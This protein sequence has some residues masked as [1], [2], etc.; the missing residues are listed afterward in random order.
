MSSVRSCSVTRCSSRRPVASKT[1]SSTLVALA[2]NNEK[3]TPSPS[4]VA[5]RGC[6]VPG[7]TAVI[8]AMAA[9]RTSAEVG[10]SIGNISMSAPSG[11]HGGERA[12]RN[13][14]P[15]G[16]ITE[17]V[18]Q[19]VQGLLDLKQ[20]QERLHGRERLVELGAARDFVIHADESFAHALLPLI[21]ERLPAR[22]VIGALRRGS[23]KRSAARVGEG[24]Q[25]A[26][27]VAQR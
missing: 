16:A 14:G 2:E 17:F 27:D 1:Q 19:L 26:G 13:H 23:H 8:G 21:E 6:G 24:A 18:A 4:Q 7:Q 25:H 12:D 15:F 22:A 20:A 11:A 10:W 5:P 3:L 9:E